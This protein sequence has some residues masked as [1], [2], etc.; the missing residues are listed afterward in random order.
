MYRLSDVAASVDPTNAASRAGS[1]RMW[2]ARGALQW[3]A[4]NAHEDGRDQPPAKAGSVGRLSRFRVIQIAIA[5]RLSDLGLAPNEATAAAAAFSDFGTAERL[6]SQLFADGSTVLFVWRTDTG[7]VAQRVVNARST[8][9]F[10]RLRFFL[11]GQPRGVIAI[12]CGAV[13]DD[14]AGLIGTTKRPKG[15]E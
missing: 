10:D 6:P 14:L 12:D 11:P 13:L 15:A 2:F 1:L 7:D 4:E 8:D 9:S 5:V 3:S